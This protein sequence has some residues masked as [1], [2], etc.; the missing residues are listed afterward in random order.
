MHLRLCIGVKARLLVHLPKHMLL[1][2][3]GRAHIRALGLLLIVYR[4]VH[5]TVKECQGWP[6]NTASGT[7]LTK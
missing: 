1:R 2:W 4:A 7:P 3:V 5:V 6:V